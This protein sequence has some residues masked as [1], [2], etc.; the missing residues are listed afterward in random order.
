[1]DFGNSLIIDSAQHVDMPAPIRRTDELG[2]HIPATF[3]HMPETEKPA[4]QGRTFGQFLWAWRWWIFALVLVLLFAD[5][6]VTIGRQLVAKRFLHQAERE[7]MLENWSRAVANSGRAIDWEPVPAQRW[8]A[9]CVR[10][11]ARSKA[12]RADLKNSLA[13]FNTAIDLL[14]DPSLIHEA[15][16]DLGGVYNQRAWLYERLG[17]H[18]EAIADA[19]SALALVDE[20]ER[21]RALNQ[22]AYIRALAGMEIDEGL[23]D[24][25]QALSQ[26]RQ[27]DPAYVA[28]VDTRGYLEFKLGKYPEALSDVQKAIQATDLRR[29]TFRHQ[30]INLL[31]TGRI[32]DREYRIAMREMDHDLAVM[33]HHRGEVYEKMKDSIHAE[34]DLHQALELGFDPTKGIF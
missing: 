22:R 28:Y 26:L 20:S 12:D 34:A 17:Q 23:K 18:R 29:Q 19:T 31:G 14:G 33:Y 6:L 8:E 9:Y 30:V 10:G 2:F 1:M 15:A 24:I 25:T 3:D 21:P 5:K 11:E 4:R 13:D 32:D 27:D 7:L 16:A